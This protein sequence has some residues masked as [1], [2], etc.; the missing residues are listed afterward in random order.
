[1]NRLITIF[2]VVLCLI[3]L[4]ASA[5]AASG[6]FDGRHFKGRI[7]WSAD[8][9]YND[10]DD[11]SASPVALA[12]FAACGL[13]DKLVHF[14]YNCIL[15]QSQ[16][17]MEEA[18]A[19]SVLGAARR[20][21]FRE[22]VFHDCQKDLKGA[23]ESIRLAINAS[24]TDDPL[25]FVLAG[26]MEVPALAIAQ[27]EPAK[28][29]FVYCISHNNW[30]DGYASGELVKHNKRDVIPLGVKWVQI[31]DQNPLLI[32]SP[33]GRAPKP[34]EWRPFHWMRDSADPNN[35][36]QWERLLASTRPDCSD[37][38]MS[39]FLVTGDERCDIAKL[40]SLMDE[41]KIPAP[42]NPRP[43]IRLEAENFRELDGGEVVYRKS[44]RAVSQR[45]HVSFKGDAVKRLRTVFDEPYAASGRYDIEIRCAG[46]KAGS[47]E[48][49]LLVAGRPQ[50]A[51]WQGAGPGWRTHT[52]PGV[53]IGIGDELAV[54]VRGAAGLDYLQLNLPGEG[55]PLP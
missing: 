7:A 53:Q 15:P 51:V 5:W 19:A 55:R 20:Y 54:E 2:T 30:N 27:A 36:F 33:Y 18:H 26:P 40:K 49:R 1:M 12:I 52:I 21:G 41:K 28:R 24:S 10:P 9:N 13:Q 38:G 14:D 44:D 17:R 45:I 22:A 42:I 31:M 48:F 46:G 4:G 35:R 32:S 29:Q 6:P 37:A 25:Y 16:P 50:G 43:R 34:Q 39:Y 11:W 8:G 23:I 3:S 47:C